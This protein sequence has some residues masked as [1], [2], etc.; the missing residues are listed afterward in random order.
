MTPSKTFRSATNNYRQIKSTQKQAGN[1]S[2]RRGYVCVA[3]ASL[4]FDSKYRI[5][6]SAET[7]LIKPVSVSNKSVSTSGP[8]KNWKSRQQSGLF[9]RAD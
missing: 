5:D 9:T 7:D 1:V 3:E 8:E 2:S 6:L 4:W